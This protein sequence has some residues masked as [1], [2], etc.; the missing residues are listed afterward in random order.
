LTT[1]G[2]PTPHRRIPSPQAKPGSASHSTIPQPTS[3]TSE[4][5]V[6]LANSK[7]LPPTSP[8]F[9]KPQPTPQTSGDP[10]LSRAVFP[11]ASPGVPSAP[12]SS[13]HI[14]STSGA[15]SNASKAYLQEPSSMSPTATITTRPTFPTSETSLSLARGQVSETR[16]ELP[17]AYATP[18][19]SSTGAFS[20]FSKG[21]YSHKYHPIGFTTPQCH[22]KLQQT[23]A[24]PT[25]LPSYNEPSQLSQPPK[26]AL[27]AAQLSK[28][29]AQ[30]T[31]HSTSGS[32]QTVPLGSATLHTSLPRSMLPHRTGVAPPFSPYRSVSA[33]SSSSTNLSRWVPWPAVKAESSQSITSVQLFTSEMKMWSSLIIAGII[34]GAIISVVVIIVQKE[35]EPKQPWYAHPAS[36]GLFVVIIIAISGLRKKRH[37]YE[38][39]E[40][41]LEEKTPPL[42]PD[43]KNYNEKRILTV[44]P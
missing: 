25:S 33:K 40:L 38:K 29:I 24:P 13:Q 16:S 19:H 31:S 18:K 17:L 43:E 10:R 36:F 2:T 11:Q 20:N 6:T 23:E 3:A 44:G 35:E 27:S 4:A 34:L 32:A 14:S 22:K 21:Y 39:G 26:T 7:C 5:S 37:H 42:N 1:F 30:K 9:A 12:I 28:L 8:A 41:Q 15:Y